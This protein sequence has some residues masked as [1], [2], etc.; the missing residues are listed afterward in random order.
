MQSNIKNHLKVKLGHQQPEGCLQSRLTPPQP[1]PMSTSMWSPKAGTIP[2]GRRQPPRQHSLPGG[3]VLAAREQ[4]SVLPL[5]DPARNPFQGRRLQAHKPLLRVG[6]YS[7][8]SHKICLT[9]P[10]ECLQNSRRN[11]NLLVYQ[12]GRY[13]A[14]GRLEPGKRCIHFASQRYAQGN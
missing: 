2:G 1:K 14:R 13:I 8:Q 11:S 3:K 5:L 6:H 10:H 7:P 9:Q 4:V 12:P